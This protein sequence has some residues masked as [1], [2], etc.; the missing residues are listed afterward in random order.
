MLCEDCGFVYYVNPS[1]AVSVF[2]RNDKRELLVCER[3]KDPAKGT[4]DLPG[5]FVDNDET[6]ED[7]VAREIKEELNVEVTEV[8]YLFSI[9]NEY[10]YSN[11][12]VPTLDMF[13]ECRVKSFD[14][15]Q[16]ADDVTRCEFLPVGK[17]SPDDFGLKSVKKA[18]TKFLS[19]QGVR[20]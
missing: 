20:F 3:G 10:L 16:A 13:Y 5:G 7:A 19:D 14:T 11:L 8:K 1:S 6:A 2:I 12:T 15:L 17:I 9:P 4:L 18:V